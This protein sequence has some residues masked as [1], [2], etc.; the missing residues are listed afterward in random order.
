MKRKILGDFGELLV[1]K[2]LASKGHEILSRQYRKWGGEID[3]ISR[4]EGV[5]YFTEVKTRVVKGDK[6]LS[7][8]DLA[9]IGLNRVKVRNIIRCAQH[10]VN[11]TDLG[12]KPSRW[13]VNACLLEVQ[14]SQS[15]NMD[16]VK[17]TE[18][19]VGLFRRGDMKVTVSTFDNLNLEVFD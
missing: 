8:K 19:L 12:L 13:Q 1:E 14:F 4:I 9:S 15:A 7:H 11:S 3:V 17:S 16:M 5:L 6:A 10:F 2:K 18:D